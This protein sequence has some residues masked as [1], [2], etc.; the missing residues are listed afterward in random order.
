MLT[1]LSEWREFPS[2]PCMCWVYYRGADKSL[3]RPGR[4]QANVSVRKAWISFGA[5]LCKKK[6]SWQFASRCCWNRA[7]PSHASEHVSFLVGL[8]T[9]QHPSICT[10]KH[11]FYFSLETKVVSFLEIPKL[12]K[13]SEMWFFTSEISFD[14]WIFLLTCKEEVYIFFVVTWLLCVEAR[15]NKSLFSSK[16]YGSTQTDEECKC[17]P[18]IFSRV[19]FSTYIKPDKKAMQADS[20]IEHGHCIVCSSLSSSS[21]SSSSSCSWR[22][23]RVS[24]SLILKMQLVPPSLPR[25]SYVPSSFWFIL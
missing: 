1:F 17:R 5:L 3:S 4:K 11:Y 19:G 9:Y 18:R 14:K 13:G 15:H 25:S 23:R 7:R 16:C 21:S 8:R 22:V 20:T 2:T 6:T 24:C 10:S 12:H